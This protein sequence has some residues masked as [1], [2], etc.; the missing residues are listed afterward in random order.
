[1]VEIELNSLFKRFFKLSAYLFVIFTSFI[2][3]TNCFIVHESAI[4]DKDKVCI[5]YFYTKKHQAS[6]RIRL[7]FCYIK[8]FVT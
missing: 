1:M 8:L 3:A 4:K 2:S 7:M 6:N 5:C